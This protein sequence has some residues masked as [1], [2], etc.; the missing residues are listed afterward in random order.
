MSY[1]YLIQGNILEQSV[2]YAVAK[3]TR[4]WTKYYNYLIDEDDLVISNEELFQ[5]Q[6]Q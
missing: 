2:S 5:A 1:A 4:K 3:K 6:R